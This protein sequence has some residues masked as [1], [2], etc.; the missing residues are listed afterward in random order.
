MQFQITQEYFYLVIKQDCQSFT[1]DYDSNPEKSQLWNTC[2]PHMCVIR[3]KWFLEELW[4]PSF[5]DSWWCQAH[6]QSYFLKLKVV[7][8]SCLIGIA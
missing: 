7:V 3:P 5:T 1:P 4:D 2:I 8:T 6:L